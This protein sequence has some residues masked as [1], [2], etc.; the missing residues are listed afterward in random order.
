VVELGSGSSESQPRIHWYAKSDR[1]FL[2]QYAC[3]MCGN[4]FYCSE[5]KKFECF[6]DRARDWTPK[7]VCPSRV[8]AEV[9]QL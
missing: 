7:R 3:W 8:D 9:V 5:C 2:R 1:D 4:L 6:L